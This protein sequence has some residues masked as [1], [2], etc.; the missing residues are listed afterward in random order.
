MDQTSHD[1]QHG[2]LLHVDM[3]SVARK[4]SIYP[5]QHTPQ[6]LYTDGLAPEVTVECSQSLLAEEVLTSKLGI[7][8]APSGTHTGFMCCKNTAARRTRDVMIS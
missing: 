5:S 7:G 4:Y 1:D 3:V 6:I 2:S 8:C